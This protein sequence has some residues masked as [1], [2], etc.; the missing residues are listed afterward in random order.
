MNLV[1]LS[2]VRRW[3]RWAGMAS[4]LGFVFS[5]V[6]LS[7]GGCGSSDE[8]YYCDNAG[9]YSC[10][11]YGCTNV[12]PP[13]YQSCTG[14]KDCGAGYACTATGCQKNCGGNEDCTRGSVCQSGMC[15]SPGT[16]PGKPIECTTKADCGGTGKLCVDNK[17]QS[18]GGSSGPCP[19]TVKADCDGANVCAGGKCTAPV[20]TCKYASE[21]GDGKSCANGQCVTP[22]SAEGTCAG[23]LTCSKGVCIPDPATP[24]P[25]CA[26][27]PSSCGDGKYC[28]Q[29]TCVPDTRPKPICSDTDKSACKENQ[30]C[31]GGYCK[32]TC[33]TDD[34][35]RLIDA[36]IAYCG[37]DKVCRTAEEAQPQ[38]T[39]QGECSGGLT[40][41]DNQCR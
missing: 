34:N 30:Q 2:D 18:C 13:S 11:G 24:G 40:C 14:S 17:C 22:C 10:D 41:I 16:E 26:D 4:M 6:A 27:N 31:V 35:C 5:T 20:D 9:C 36:R 3:C 25:S 39:D 8:R 32:F 37:K 29:G 1:G 23:G 21:C 28:N 7:S 33:A 12:A 19:C 38:C 15:T